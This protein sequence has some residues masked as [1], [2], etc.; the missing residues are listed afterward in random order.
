MGRIYC[1]SRLSWE[2]RGVVKKRKIIKQYRRGEGVRAHMFHPLSY[3]PLTCARTFPAVYS[4]HGKSIHIRYCMQRRCSVGQL[5]VDST[6]ELPQSHRSL[7]WKCERCTGVQQTIIINVLIS[8]HAGFAAMLYNNLQAP[9][10]TCCP[11]TTTHND[12]VFIARK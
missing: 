8:R 7:L 11:V 5:Q 12:R 1:I 4:D 9:V 3:A 10:T 2:S 6:A